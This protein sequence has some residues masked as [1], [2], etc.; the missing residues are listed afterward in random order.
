MYISVSMAGGS[1]SKQIHLILPN[2]CK[3]KMNDALLM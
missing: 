1:E 3:R 2:F